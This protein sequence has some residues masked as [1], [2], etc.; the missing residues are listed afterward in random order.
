M[1]V[2]A[3][4]QT[5]AIERGLAQ[6][7]LLI[8]PS[9]TVSLAAELL[10]PTTLAVVLVYPLGELSAT[11]A[12]AQITDALARALPIFVVVP[13]EFSD[14]KAR[15]LYKAGA[16]AVLE[17]PYEALLLPTMLTDLV[18]AAPRKRTRGDAQLTRAVQTRLTLSERIMGETSA[19]VVGGVARVSGRVRSYWAR[20][21]VED[22]L[23]HVPGI[24]AVNTDDVKVVTT[25]RPDPQLLRHVRNVL[26]GMAGIDAAT[27]ST[28]VAEGE[29]TLAGNVA[30]HADL[31][32]ILA[33]VGNVAGV[34]AIHNLLVVSRAQ[35]KRARGLATRLNRGIAA[36]FPGE[37]AQ[38]T[39]FGSVAVLNGHTRTLADKRAV[40]GYCGDTDGIETVVNKL[41][42][43]A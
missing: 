15:K 41:T 38:A 22:L 16:A 3:R 10:S 4:V 8:C 42:V 31:Q 17:W 34:R 9:P 5:R 26:R 36:L 6:L 32:R 14:E 28:R 27:I 1:V 7:D 23:S 20:Q 2:G 37:A 25:A 11:R 30:T 18:G 43:L 24:V 12:V 13:D 39:V 29:V 40:G 33:V 35:T 19:Q 21:R